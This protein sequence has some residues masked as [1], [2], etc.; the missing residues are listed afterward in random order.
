MADIAS[1]LGYLVLGGLFVWAGIDHFLRF[2]A[3]RG[4][5]AGRGWPE[6]G[7]VLAVASLLQ[8]VAGLGV[9]LDVMRAAAALGLAGFTLAASLLLLDFW[10]LECEHRAAARSGLAVNMGLIGGLLVGFGD[11]L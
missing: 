11:S 10:R 7:P 6:P 5:L 8:I 9:A 2:D 1:G 4:M 3:V